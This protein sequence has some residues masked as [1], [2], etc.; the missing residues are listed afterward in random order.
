MGDVIAQDELVQAL[1]E[2]NIHLDT[3]M[4]H[5]LV[6]G[7]LHNNEIERAL[8]F[9]RDLRM[10]GVVP[11]RNTYN[12]LISVSGDSHDAEEMFRLLLDFKDTW[13]DNSIEEGTWWT[14]LDACAKEG[15]V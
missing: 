8:L 7:L 12:L 2:H 15:Y 9:L 5:S 10:Q 13:G 6:E 3:H 1:I 11:K 14:V 4:L